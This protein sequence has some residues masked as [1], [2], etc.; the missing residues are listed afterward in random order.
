MLVREWNIVRPE[1]FAKKM[2]APELIAQSAVKPLIPT[3]AN[4]Q[5]P[6]VRIWD[7]TFWGRNVWDRSRFI[8]RMI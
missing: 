3:T 7:T 1:R 4:N 8:V 5:L 2:I 6:T